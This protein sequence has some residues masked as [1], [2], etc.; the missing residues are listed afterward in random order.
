MLSKLLEETLTEVKT[1]MLV[2]IPMMFPLEVLSME[3][4][5]LPARSVNEIL[6]DTGLGSL[7]N[8]TG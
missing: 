1:G 3:T 5:E 4:P 8:P 7:I 6:K 2:S